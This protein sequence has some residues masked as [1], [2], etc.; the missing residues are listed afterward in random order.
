MKNRV[1]TSYHTCKIPLEAIKDIG[2]LKLS[3]TLRNKCYHFFNF[4][5][6]E[7]EGYKQVPVTYLKKVY[8]VKCYHF[9]NPLK[10][11]GIIEVFKSVNEKGVL[12]ESYSNIANFSKS[13]RINPKYLLSTQFE[14]LEIP[15][16][17]RNH[18]ITFTNGKESFDWDT[19]FLKEDFQRLVISRK[20]LEEEAKRIIEAISASDFEIDYQ[21]KTHQKAVK[22]E[23]KRISAN[24]GDYYVNIE[25]FLS[26]NKTSK[27][28]IKDNNKFYICN[29]DEY[30]KRKKENKAKSYAMHID[31][32]CKGEITFSRNKT[33]NRLDSNISLM[34]KKLLSVIKQQTGL[35]EIDMRNAQP[36]MLSYLMN[37]DKSFEPAQDFYNF[38]TKCEE[39]TLYD[40]LASK[41]D[42]TREDIKLLIFEILFGQKLISP[43]AKQFNNEFPS[44]V[45]YKKSYSEKNN[46]ELLSV[47]LQ[48]LESGIFIDAMYRQLKSDGFFCLTKHDSL[49]VMKD[50]A[51]EILNNYLGALNQIGFNGSF[52]IEDGTKTEKE[53]TQ[54]ENQKE[55]TVNTLS[56][57][58]EKLKNG[59]YSTSKLESSKQSKPIEA[60]N[61]I[62]QAR[63]EAVSIEE[64]KDY[65]LSY[66]ESVNMLGDYFS[67]NGCKR[68]LRLATE[69]IKNF[70]RKYF[71]KSDSE[72]GIAPLSFSAFELTG[73]N[74][75]TILSNYLSQRD[76]ATG[77]NGLGLLSRLYIDIYADVHKYRMAKPMLFI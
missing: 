52:K 1:K 31:K 60:A 64:E 36:M 28:L 48:K 41:F 72:L 58:K 23:N 33:N 66:F 14:E 3:R 9:I 13:Y 45:N 38:K 55:N 67:S 69:E 5:A 73:K 22:I 18:S 15:V 29:V 76:A 62:I 39:G 30:V 32:I 51:E 26:E 59:G 74:P 47:G 63:K 46:G 44:I 68:R 17:D 43:L 77:L 54:M 70:E 6:N 49:I 50:N 16:F 37:E 4:L 34:P 53:N 65:M 2:A 75:N 56:S 7:K 12:K 10:D 57:I 19:D 11:A 27:S 24:G 20:R 42:T 71:A 61:A 35:V 25:K 21:I 40:Y 8:T